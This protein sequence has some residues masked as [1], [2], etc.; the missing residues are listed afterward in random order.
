MPK[1]NNRSVV[2]ESLGRPIFQQAN[3][4]L[5]AAAVI[6]AVARHVASN[7][8][9][10]YR[11]RIRSDAARCRRRVTPVVGQDVDRISNDHRRLPRCGVQIPLNVNGVTRDD[12]QAH[13]KDGRAVL[14]AQ[15][16]LAGRD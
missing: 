3:E 7:Q 11:C 4:V 15:A 10:I 16:A 9:G 14:D 8:R 5:R 13:R 2:G 1:L 6:R 12:R